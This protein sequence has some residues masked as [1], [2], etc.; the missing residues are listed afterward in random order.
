MVTQQLVT[1]LVE[2]GQHLLSRQCRASAKTN[3]QSFRKANRLSTAAINCSAVSM[4][5]FDKNGR[6]TSSTLRCSC[7]LRCLRGWPLEAI[8]KVSLQM[9]YTA[10]SADVIL[11]PHQHHALNNQEDSGAATDWNSINSN[12]KRVTFEKQGGEQEVM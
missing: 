6:H 11:T 5:R 9:F 7:S 4:V 2:S 3:S 1:P 8:T 10:G 12:M